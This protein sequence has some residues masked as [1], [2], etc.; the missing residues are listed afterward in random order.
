M[1]KEFRQ[2]ILN[3]FTQTFG[4]KTPSSIRAA[5]EKWVKSFFD[6]GQLRI[7]NKHWVTTWSEVVSNIPGQARIVSQLDAIPEVLAG[8]GWIKIHDYIVKRFADRVFMNPMYVTYEIDYNIQQITI[9]YVRGT[10]RQ[11]ARNQDDIDLEAYVAKRLRIVMEDF[12]QTGDFALI[13][14]DILKE[15][16]GKTKGTGQTIS[17]GDTI[18]PEFGMQN[19]PG[20]A[21]ELAFKPGGTMTFDS[22]LQSEDRLAKGLKSGRGTAPGAKGTLVSKRFLVAIIKGCTEEF[23]KKQWFTQVHETIDAKWAELFGYSSSVETRDTKDKVQDNIGLSAELIATKYLNKF[24]LNKGDFDRALAKEIEFFLKDNDYFAS[25]LVRLK[26]VN[27]KDAAKLSSGSDTTAERMEKAAIKLAATNVLENIQAKNIKK[28]KKVQRSKKKGTS[29]TK[30]KFKGG[31]AVKRKTTRANVGAKRRGR[32]TKQAQAIG[33]NVLA[34]K[35][36]INKLLPDAV[37]A[38]MQSPALVNRTGR[39]RRSAEVTNAMIGPR[40]GVQIDYTYQRD[41]YEVFEPGSG[42]PLANQ[43]RDPRRII[44]GTVREIAQSIMG[45]KFVRVRRV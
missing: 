6:R 25:E 42:S 45:K 41:P 9:K 43:Y 7:T 19:L 15:A 24:N 23:R 27:A 36:L 37:L 33:G 16:L 10:K 2:K 21:G 14:E 40:G 22:R 13:T 1:S 26:N 31:S 17:H 20:A 32:P 8:R 3:E 4:K 34:L 30:A 18:E 11:G 35:E 28:R 39:F 44:G 38:K 29:K 5:R 12:F